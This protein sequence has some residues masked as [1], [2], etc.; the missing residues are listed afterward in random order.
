MGKIYTKGGDKGE[1]SLIGGVRVLKGSERVSLY[2]EVD[3]L[4][5]YIGLAL[6][7]LDEDKYLFEMEEDLLLK[8][9]EELF[10][11]GALL[12]C[13]SKTRV[14]YKLKQIETSLIDNMEERIDVLNEELP[15]LANF[16]IP[17]GC[18]EASHLHVCRSICR[19]V[20]R[21]AV[22]FLQHNKDELPDNLLMFLNRLSDYLFVFSRYVNLKRRT[23]ECLVR[24]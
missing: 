14:E 15:E 3:E 20:E 8:I 24:N 5:S 13:E 11:I 10:H 1:T 16:I 18:I 17:G 12:A 2:G 19:R 21:S 6:S 22:T 4:N 7:F 23:E 9:Q